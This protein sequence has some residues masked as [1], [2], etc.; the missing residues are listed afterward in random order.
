[1]AKRKRHF[2]DNPRQMAAAYKI[3][4]KQVMLETMTNYVGDCALLVLNDEFGFGPERLKR[5]NTALDAEMKKWWQVTAAPKPGDK[6]SEIGYIRSK[7]DEALKRV[8]GD[9]FVPFEQRYE[10]IDNNV[11]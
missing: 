8:C 1:M 10:W 5:F 11:I 7:F 6:T 4:S 2:C 9:K 3:A